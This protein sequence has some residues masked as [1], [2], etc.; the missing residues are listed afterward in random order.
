MTLEL[1]FVVAVHDAIIVELGGLPG[2]AAAGVG[3][4]E[5]ALFRIDNHAA[6]GGADD[7]FVIAAMYAVAI[8]RG[9]VFNDAN[10][11]TG[12]TCA[13]TYLDQQG[14]SLPKTP[15]LEQVMVEVAEGRIDQEQLADYL[16]SL[17]SDFLEDELEK[18]RVM[19]ELG[20][21]FGDPD[22]FR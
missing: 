21:E 3:G 16:S 17:W 19:D 6:Y 4:V 1:D 12:L 22:L 14:V 2:F 7:V 10:K 11:R 5:S 13:L 20:W 18:L 8:A 15:A 9:H